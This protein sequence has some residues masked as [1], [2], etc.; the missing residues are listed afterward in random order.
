[1][2]LALGL[3]LALPNYARDRVPSETARLD[4]SSRPASP[5]FS[6]VWY[7]CSI[8]F[9]SARYPGRVDL[10]DSRLAFALDFA[11]LAPRLARLPGEARFVQD[12]EDRVACSPAVTHPALAARPA[13]TCSATKWPCHPVR[14]PACGG[15]PSGSA[16]VGAPVDRLRTATVPRCNRRQTLPVE[17]GDQ[18]GHGITGTP[19]GSLSRLLCSS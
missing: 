1:M 9:F 4:R 7:A 11:G 6:P 8:S 5:S 3:P 12:H 2:R 18:L 17:T 19:P 13:V 15:L 10:H 16:H 14:D